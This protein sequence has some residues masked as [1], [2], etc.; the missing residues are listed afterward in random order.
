M[1]ALFRLDSGAVWRSLKNRF[2]LALVLVFGLSFCV[3]AQTLG[4]GNL[5]QTLSLNHQRIQVNAAQIESAVVPSKGSKRATALQINRQAQAFGRAYGGYVL[6]NEDGMQTGMIELAQLQVQGAQTGYPGLKPSTLPTI[7]AATQMRLVTQQIHARHQRLSR[8]VNSA[9][10]TLNQFWPVLL[11]VLPALAVAVCCDAWLMMT[12]HRSVT[13]AIPVGLAGQAATKVV[14]RLG[15]VGLAVGGSV[16]AAGLGGLTQGRLG[17]FAYPTAIAL[18]DRLRVMPLWGTLLLVLLMTGLVTAF[19]A[20]LMLCLNLW[21]QNVYLSALIGVG[22]LS[23]PWLLPSL[24]QALWFL[25]LAGLAPT[26]VFSGALQ[27]EAGNWALG[28]GGV[29]VILLGWT[30]AFIALFRWTAAR[31]AG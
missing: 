3:I 30:G 23:L 17:D 31:A 5:K 10:T 4:L 9:A 7:S 1:K 22:L 25:P 21:T 15:L 19:V 29:S 14:T 8:R 2:L 20:T 18:G 27:A 16:V 11:A 24:C 6:G 12:E 28:I 26:Q 13:A